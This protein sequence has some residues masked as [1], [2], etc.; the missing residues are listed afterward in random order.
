MTAPTRA[1]IRS[2]IKLLK[3]LSPALQ[4][5]LPRLGDES[6]GAHELGSMVNQDPILAARVL[7]LANSPFYGLPRQVGSLE[8]AVLILGVSHL[9]GMVLST[10]LIALF[11]D[12]EA[13][14]RSLATAA[15]AR[16][17]AK[18]LRQDHG[19]ALTAGLLHNLGALLLGH[20]AP[21]LW[22]SLADEAEVGIESRFQ[23]EKAVF[24]FDYCELGADIAG[25]WHFPD[26]IR[27][28]I[29]LHAQPSGKPGEGLVDLVHIAWVIGTNKP[30]KENNLFDPGVLRRLGLHEG[31]AGIA[32]VAA[33]QAAQDSRGALASL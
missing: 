27:S 25:D 11:S 2:G 33:S 26:M 7:H 17:L 23:H 10:G 19:M 28:A 4:A 15:A 6:L 16:S 24:G 20:F 1:E 8:E 22:Q 21:E 29:R 13:I 31:V 3:G 32:L 9:R 14:A 30:L 12:S 5:I 18:S